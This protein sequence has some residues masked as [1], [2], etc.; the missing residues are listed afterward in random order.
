MLDEPREGARPQGSAVVGQRNQPSLG[1][2]VGSS[3]LRLRREIGS[4]RRD[5]TVFTAKRPSAAP[6]AMR[7]ASTCLRCS[8]FEAAWAITRVATRSFALRAYKSKREHLDM[9]MSELASATTTRIRIDCNRS[10]RRQTPCS[11]HIRSTRPA[12]QRKRKVS[13]PDTLAAVQPVLASC[14]A[15]SPADVQ[16]LGAAPG[17]RT[18]KRLVRYVARPPL[19]QERLE[20]TPDRSRPRALRATSGRGFFAESSPWTFALAQTAVEPCGSSP[21]QRH[22]NRWPRCSKVA[23]RDRARHR[24]HP[25]SSRSTSP[26]LEACPGACPRASRDPLRQPTAPPS[27]RSGGRER[28]SSTARLCAGR[29][30]RPRRARPRAANLASDGLGPLRPVRLVVARSSPLVP[31]SAGSGRLRR[32][33]SRMDAP[34]PSLCRCAPLQTGHPRAPSPR[35]DPASESLGAHSRRRRDL[36]RRERHARRRVQRLVTTEAGFD[37]GVPDGGAG[38]DGGMPTGDGGGAMGRNG[39]RAARQPRWVRLRHDAARCLGELRGRSVGDRRAL[40]TAAS[41]TERRRLSRPTR[42]ARARPTVRGRRTPAKNE[43]SSALAVNA[44]FRSTDQIAPTSPPTSAPRPPHPLLMY[45]AHVPAR[46]RPTMAL[47]NGAA[48][49]TT[50]GSCTPTASSGPSTGERELIRARPAVRHRG[51]VSLVERRVVRDPPSDGEGHPRHRLEGD[52][53]GCAAAE[54]GARVGRERQRENR[55]ER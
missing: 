54:R 12:R 45:R 14:Y 34:T 39:H 10:R 1:G 19:S 50:T 52:T 27:R 16:L 37:G 13:V 29:P 28:R 43:S 38:G 51:P 46:S 21:S 32:N 25:A 41:L 35:P 15:A 7:A 48:S 26:Q 24:R 8:S 44:T 4:L 33:P 18:E 47:A 3:R 6:R 30:V 20:T 17:Q 31:E 55:R 11:V 49:P 42:R 22:S 40:P 23:H 5:R 36:R 2:R 9:R 53:Q